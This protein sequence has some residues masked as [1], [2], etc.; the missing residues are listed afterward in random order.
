MCLLGRTQGSSQPLG[1][2]SLTE[3]TRLAEEAEEVEEGRLCVSCSWQA[4]ADM[5]LPIR[6]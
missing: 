6:L 5:G 1:Q 4:N 3:R 2:S